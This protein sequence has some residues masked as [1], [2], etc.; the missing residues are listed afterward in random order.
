MNKPLQIAEECLRI[1]EQRQQIDLVHDNPERELIRVTK[2]NFTNYGQCQTLPKQALSLQTIIGKYLSSIYMN[3]TK[4][5]IRCIVLYNR[6]NL[7]YMAML[8][9][10]QAFTPY[11]IN[12]S[13][14]SV[15]TNNKRGSG[16]S[17]VSK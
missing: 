12:C 15:A 16:V 13:K 4:R 2:S 11:T 7:N 8:I 9:L 5:K 3:N 1:R 14:I 10:I 17:P 6:F